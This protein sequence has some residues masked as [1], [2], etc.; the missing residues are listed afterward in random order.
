MHVHVHRMSQIGRGED[1]TAL[2]NP[3]HALVLGDHPLH[4]ILPRRH[5]PTVEWFGCQACPEYNPIRQRIAGGDA[6]L[7]RV[8]RE[9]RIGQH[10]LRKLAEQRHPR[11]STRANKKRATADTLSL[12]SLP[13]KAVHTFLPCFSRGNSSRQGN[14]GQTRPRPGARA[15]GEI[16]RSVMLLE[17]GFRR[18]GHSLW[19]ATI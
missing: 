17:P 5:S 9:T 16:P 4:G 13:P 7:E 3:A 15:L 10:L 8:I 1:R 18:E 14:V 19:P 12:G 2:D 6:Q 11:Q